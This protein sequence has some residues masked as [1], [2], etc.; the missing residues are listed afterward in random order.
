MVSFFEISHRS[1]GR[2]AMDN[3]FEE[4]LEIAF[5]ELQGA[6]ISAGNYK[7]DLY[8][9]LR[10][11]GLRVPP[12]YYCSFVENLIYY[13]IWFGSVWGAL[14]WFRSVSPASMSAGEIVLALA[15]SGLAYGALMALY[16]RNRI[17]KYRLTPWRE[18]GPIPQGCSRI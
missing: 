14:M 5:K 7:T 17:K 16:Y 11:M 6:G 4:R 1:V 9:L 12:P 10:H 13:A 8:Q 15:G 2:G 3:T 18:L